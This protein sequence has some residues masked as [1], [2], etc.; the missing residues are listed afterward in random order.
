MNHIK[1]I[2]K[3]NTA[4]KLRSSSFYE[5]TTFDLYA[6]IICNGMV[7]LATLKIVEH[8]WYRRNSILLVVRCHFEC[9]TDDQVKKANNENNDGNYHMYTEMYFS[10]IAIGLMNIESTT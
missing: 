9:Y 3:W 8:F 2:F 7:I 10:S 1:D 6:H 5:M 4:L